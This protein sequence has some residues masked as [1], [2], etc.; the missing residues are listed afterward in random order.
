M[1]GF[2]NQYILVGTLSL[3]TLLVMGSDV[4]RTQ[5]ADTDGYH[6]AWL[7]QNAY[8]T[9]RA[10]EST[11]LEVSLRNTGSATW[12]RGSVNLG[13]DRGQDR[14]PEFIREDRLASQPSGWLKEN[15]VGLVEESIA[16]GAIAT[17]RFWY[18][19]PTNYPVGTRREYFRPVADAITWMEDMGIYWDVTVVD[20]STP[21]IASAAPNPLAGL[22]FSKNLNSAA[23]KQAVL[24]QATQP[25]DA[26]Q[27]QKIA[28][29]PEA[30]WLAG[31]APTPTDAVHKVSAAIT[32]A[33]AQK[34][35]PVFVLYAIPQR[36][37][38]GLAA[39]GFTSADNYIAWAQA[40]AKSIGTN[41]AVTIVEPDA[42]DNLDCL[43]PADQQMRYNLI[44]QAIQILK[45]NPLNTVYLDAGNPGWKP[46]KIMV[47]RLQ[48]AGIDIADGFSLNVA[49]FFTDA[50]N[51]QFG[52]TISQQLG[53]KHFVIDTGRNGLGAD[54]NLVWCNPTGRALGSRPT[55]V[56]GN[57]LV[58]AFL[59]V[60][61]PGYSDGACRGSAVSYGWW[62]EYALG[63]AQ[64]AAY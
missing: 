16:P 8:P 30:I 26:A 1:W 63:L 56:T 44:K 10:G 41:R 5:A 23:A 15:R 43:G 46:A 64:R 58:D 9:L 53:N 21:P 22:R 19:V 49:S 2:M 50:Q 25:A 13:T 28:A 62:P 12:L 20:G 60:K 39:G 17:Y 47:P 24:W 31:I 36:D 57:P 27:M 52:T 51:I 6:A 59:W 4:H 32:T 45:T 29:Q 11:L 3:I 61:Q 42:L 37:C 33:Q 34:T 54:P 7:S 35:T 55:T 40:I 38:G 48:A 14:I 18:T